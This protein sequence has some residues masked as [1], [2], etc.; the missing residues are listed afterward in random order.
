M[1]PPATQ[2]K[3]LSRASSAP[4]APKS[5]PKKTP[6]VPSIAERAAAKVKSQCAPKQPPAAKLPPKPKPVI[7]VKAEQLLVA[8]NMLSASNHILETA[9]AL[10][11][12]AVNPFWNVWISSTKKAACSMSSTLSTSAWQ[13]LTFQRQPP[14]PEVPF[15][16]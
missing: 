12:E 3:N 11:K 8:Q 6:I 16:D 1:P 5:V 10:L 4:V 9:Q 2:T 14:F 15:T 13:I 7:D